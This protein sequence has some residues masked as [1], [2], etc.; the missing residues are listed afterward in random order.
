MENHVF[1]V[2][3]QISRGAPLHSLSFI[4]A[5]FQL[6]NS[7]GIILYVV[8]NLVSSLVKKSYNHIPIDYEL[9]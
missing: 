7:T 1:S 8:C 4:D 6:S 2:P 9:S 3:A 5:E